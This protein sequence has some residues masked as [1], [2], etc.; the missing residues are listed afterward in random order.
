MDKLYII[1]PL[2]FVILLASTNCLSIH[3]FYALENTDV[4]SQS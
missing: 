3:T 1:T 4:V 2:L